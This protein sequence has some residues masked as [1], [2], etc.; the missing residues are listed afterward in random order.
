VLASVEG[1]VGPQACLERG[2]DRRVDAAHGTPIAENGVA[3]GTGR[4]DGEQVGLLACFFPLITIIVL[5]L[6]PARSRR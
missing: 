5:L 1:E 6:I 2:A 3:A 4:L